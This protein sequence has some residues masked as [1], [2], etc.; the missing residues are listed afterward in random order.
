MKRGH[1][2]LAVANEFL[3][4]EEGTQ[5]RLTAMHLQK[6]CYMAHGFTWALLDEPMTSDRIE[7]WDYGPVYPRLYDALRKYGSEPIP[8]L[9][10]QNNWADSE[11]VRGKIV[12]DEFSEREHKIIDTVWADYGEFEAFQLSTLTH[13]DDSPWAK[14]YEPGKRSITIPDSLIKEYFLEITKLR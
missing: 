14:V 4:K 13:E 12:Q 10:Y 7:A 2:V 8:S 5:S 6:F 11:R 9:I 1:N 3:L